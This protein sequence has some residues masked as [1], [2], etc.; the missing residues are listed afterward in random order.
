MNSLKAMISKITILTLIISLF[1]SSYAFIGVSWQTQRPP[2]AAFD[3]GPGPDVE[4]NEILK[5]LVDLHANIPSF[6]GISEELMRYSKVWGDSVGPTQKFRP[7]YGPIPWRMILQPN[8]VKILFIGQDGTH[9]AEA[10]GRP[11]TAGFGGRAQ[12]LAAFF[13]VEYSAGFINTYAFTIKGQYA[14]RSAPYVYDGKF[15]TQGSVTPNDVW[16]ITQDQDSPIAKWRS[17]LIEWIINNNRESLKLI[18]LFGGSAKDSIASFIESRGGKVGSRNESDMDKI[19]VPEFFMEGS[20]GNGEFPVP[21]SKDGKD[22]YAKLAGKDFK[23]TKN[24][25]G[26]AAS[27]GAKNS[28]E[29]IENMVFTKAGPYKNGLLHHAQMGGYDLDQIYIDRKNTSKPTR[30]LKGLKL[31]KGGVI[32]NDILVAALPHPTYLSHTMNDGA[33]EY[34]EDALKDNETYKEMKG[35]AGNIPGYKKLDFM[36]KVLRAIPDRDFAKRIDREGY[37]FGKEK[38]ANLVER[39]VSQLRPYAAKGWNIPADAS[40][41]KQE[42]INTFAQGKKYSYGRSDIHTVYYDF[43][44]PNNRMVSRSTARRNGSQV[45]VFG[46]RDV[47]THDSKKL[48]EM[49]KQKPNQE[50][51]PDQMFISRVRTPE[52]RY[53]FDPGPSRDYAELMKDLDFDEIYKEKPGM[54][55]GKDGI[56]AYNIKSHPESIGDFGHYRG[57][58]KNPRAVI[59]AD[60]DGYD[61]LITA[62][63]LT[64]TRGQYLQGLM[65][66]LGIEDQY[67]LIKTVPFGMDGASKSEW[68]IVLDQTKEYRKNLLAKIL[69]ENSPELII[70]DGANAMKSLKRLLSKEDQRKLVLIEREGLAN[71]SGVIDAGIAIK[72]KYDQ[73]SKTRIEGKMNNIPKSHLSYY[74]RTW[75]GTTGDRVLAAT[76]KKYEGI[77]FLEVAPN[78]VRNQEF[79]LTPQT[80]KE[81][82]A[83]KE[84][85]FNEGF[86]LPSETIQEYLKRIKSESQLDA[87]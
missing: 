37:Q 3:P 10:A 8:N 33:I 14:A 29:M 2:L 67:L 50:L 24:E 77:A 78:W 17:D 54:S 83:I 9:V 41:Q 31:K 27:F 75:E 76:G 79:D 20:G 55:F 43:G 74:A 7:V 21:Y 48:S 60:P 69:A 25:G 63:A 4:K 46:T 32:E 73:F 57:T 71:G 39:D 38:V 42:N 59:V 5:E 23:Y 81:V 15:S 47:P 53:I 26:K 12:D 70:A 45:I 84:R 82:D 13:G 1:T 61:D 58:F 85:L 62:R 19:Q 86:P 11:A 80:Q 28:D 35:R 34:W 64:G 87:A 16:L 68:D 49:K 66:D 52:T 18:V 72:N 65:D 51:D 44:T 40:S 22:L 36:N 56:A 30:S 6:P